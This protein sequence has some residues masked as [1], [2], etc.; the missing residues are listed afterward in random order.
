MI[1]YSHRRRASESRTEAE[2][3]DSTYRSSTLLSRGGNDSSD[4][5]RWGGVF[6]RMKNSGRRWMTRRKPLS[7]TRL[8]EKLVKRADRGDWGGVRKLISNFD[9]SDIPEPLLPCTKLPNMNSTVQMLEEEQKH[10]SHRRPS[11]GSRSGDRLSF[12]GKE[13]AAAAAAIKAALLEESSATS[14]SE[15][16]NIGEN[17]L[18]D[19]CRYDPPLDVIE[20]LLV[21]LRHRRGATSGTDDTGR[22]PLHVASASGA[23]P[24]VINALTRADPRPASEGD[25]DGR[26]PLH[27]AVR[28]LAYGATEDNTLIGTEQTRLSSRRNNKQNGPSNEER[29]AQSVKTVL[30]LKSTMLTYPGKIDFK[31]E[32]NSGFA[33]VDYALDADVEDEYLLHCLLTRKHS[34]RKCHSMNSLASADTQLT[35][36]LGRTFPRQGSGITSTSSDA[37]DIAVLQRLE[38]E[39]IRDRRM[40]LE[41]IPRHK[42]QMKAVLFDVFGIDEQLECGPSDNSPCTEERLTTSDKVNSEKSLGVITAK[43]L[44]RSS[45][46]SSSKSTPKLQ[47]NAKEND[48]RS[49]T[50]SAIYNH[51]LQAYLNDFASCDGLEFYDDDDDEFDIHHDPEEDIEAEQLDFSAWIGPGKPPVVEISFALDSMEDDNFSQCSYG[52]SVVSE[53]TVP[54]IR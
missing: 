27:I 33:P 54:T 16:P 50:D 48:C 46:V 26:S 36:N 25:N 43:P 23:S 41:R 32:D 8:R 19:I 6:S 20:T 15:K 34:S 28:S 53:V 5:K 18:H 24:D 13:S 40:R 42:K 31:D 4:P 12:T 51:H 10:S 44:R 3:T 17:V 37:Q 11:Y 52:R 21:S 1:P 39:E 22:T 38:E 14:S 47:D 49:M 29:I 9:F 35:S 2:Y 7:E 45:E 30:L